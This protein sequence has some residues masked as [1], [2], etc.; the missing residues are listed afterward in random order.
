MTLVLGTWSPKDPS[1]LKPHRAGLAN[2]KPEC[3]E[4]DVLFARISTL[5]GPSGPCLR[6]TFSL[7]RGCPWRRPAA[8]GPIAASAGLEMKEARITKEAL[9]L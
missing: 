3:S 9:W 6:T 7:M 8:P 2:Q 4:T 5:W 1:S